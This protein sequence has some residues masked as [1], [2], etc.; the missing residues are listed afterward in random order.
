MT[1][2]VLSRAADADLANI[3]EYS[4]AEH[5]RNA[6]EAYLRDFERTFGRLRDFPELGALYTILDPKLRCLPCRQHLVFYTI[7]DTQIDIVRVLHKAMDIGS[8]L[9]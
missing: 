2:V 9:Q 3:L 4:I 5:G 7:G 8:R 6:A 1:K